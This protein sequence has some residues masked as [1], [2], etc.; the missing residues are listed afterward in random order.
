MHH[1]SK[2]AA[3]AGQSAVRAMSVATATTANKAVAA[4]A[5][6]PQS[7][8]KTAAMTLAQKHPLT[9]ALAATQK[10]TSMHVQ[11]HQSSAKAATPVDVATVADVVLA[12]T[13]LT[14]QPMANLKRN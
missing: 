5:K 10:A 3:K 4:N 9:S 1:K 7:V 14:V 6:R 11:T 8:T 13:M 12:K 2:R